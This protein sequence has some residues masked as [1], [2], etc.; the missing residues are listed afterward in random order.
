METRE[1]AEKILRENLGRKAKIAA[2]KEGDTFTFDVCICEAGT[3][4]SQPILQ[5][6]GF[7]EFNRNPLGTCGND[8]AYGLEMDASFRAELGR[9]ITVVAE[10]LRSAGYRGIAG[11]DFVVGDAVHL[12]EVN[13]RLVGSLPV[14][15]ELQR[16][17]GETPFLLLHLLSF[18][19]FDFGGYE[20][21]LYGHDLAFS[22]VIL[23]NTTDGPQTVAKS[24]A[25]GIYALADG[26]L[27]FRRPAF[28]G[29]G[30]LAAGRILPGKRR[31]RSAHRS[32]HGIRQPAA[33]PMV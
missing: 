26:A 32:G 33:S 15:T 10:R 18:L 23:R 14:F 27:V 21:E 12:I 5:I 16:R 24:L 13:P 4:I 9:I 3:H 20:G 8:Y 6:T 11:F 22:Q 31:S 2:F 28:T 19:G 25:S 29:A 30:D 7:A 17:A 1:A